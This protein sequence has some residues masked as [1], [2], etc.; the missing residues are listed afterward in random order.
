MV[1]IMR[2]MSIIKKRKTTD[3]KHPHYAELR[4]ES[5]SLDEFINKTVIVDIK[6]YK[7]KK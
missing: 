1:L 4:I 7:I 5:I 3:K 6:E 2:F